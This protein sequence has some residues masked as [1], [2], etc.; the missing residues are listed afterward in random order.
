MSKLQM[1]TILI[2]SLQHEVYCSLR[3]LPQGQTVNHTYYVE[4]MKGLHEA[5]RRKR[6]EIWP[7]DWLLH[8]DE[9]PARKKHFVKQFLAQEISD[10]EHP[11]YSPDLAPNDF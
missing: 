5:V 9:V 1:K 7:T 8:H 4:K 11:S 10:T 3:I 6:P 2:T